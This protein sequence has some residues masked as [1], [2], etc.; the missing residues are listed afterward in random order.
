MRYHILFK[1]LFATTMRKP[2]RANQGN[3]KAMGFQ[4][5]DFYISSL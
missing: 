4:G 3:K 1:Y 5:K 2:F